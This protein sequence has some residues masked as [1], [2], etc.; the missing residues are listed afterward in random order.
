[1]TKGDQQGGGTPQNEKEVKK[2]DYYG[3]IISYRGGTCFKVEG[4]K[5]SDYLMQ[6]RY[7]KEKLIKE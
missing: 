5:G 1:L 6:T 3:L 2:D 7:Y 4:K